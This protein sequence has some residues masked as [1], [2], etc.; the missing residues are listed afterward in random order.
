[1]NN[2]FYFLKCICVIISLSIF[3]SCNSNSDKVKEMEKIIISAHTKANNLERDE[4]INST[5]IND[6]FTYNA[7]KH[8]IP[9]FILRQEIEGCH[10]DSISYIGHNWFKVSYDYCGGDCEEVYYWKMAKEDNKYKI[11]NGDNAYSQCT[12]QI[13]DLSY[14][15]RI[16]FWVNSRKY[17]DVQPYFQG[18]LCKVSKDDKYGFINIEGEEILPCKY[19]DITF[20]LGDLSK[21]DYNGFRS[22]DNLVRVKLDN[23]YGIVNLDGKEIIPCKY[24]DLT[25]LFD[26]GKDLLKVKLDNKYGFINFE[27]KEIIPCK[28]DDLMKFRY[29]LIKAELGNKYGFIDY[30]GNEIIQCKYDDL[31]LFDN[32]NNDLFKVKSNNKYGL[33]NL[34]ME[35]EAE[36]PVEETKEEK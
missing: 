34:E 22:G 28:Y 14:A 10:L 36:N 5:N 16:R 35:I 8:N 12:S 2:K 27:G 6:L 31:T 9:Y 30:E 11:D 18:N 29:Y 26:W 19:D 32:N 24:D 21:T 1:M 4:Y 25:I 13:K 3:S 23:K 17:D 7:T 20:V 33:I 15:D